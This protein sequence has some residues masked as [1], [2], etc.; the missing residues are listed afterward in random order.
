KM[1]FRPC[2]GENGMKPYHSP[3]LVTE[4]KYRTEVKYVLGGTTSSTRQVT[5]YV[6]HSLDQVACCEATHP[7]AAWFEAARASIRPTVE[8]DGTTSLDNPFIKIV[9]HTASGAQAEDFLSLRR[10][11]RLSADKKLLLIRRTLASR[12]TL[13]AAKSNSCVGLSIGVP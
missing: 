7:D 9:V 6:H 4:G 3:E 10:T 5:Y 13:A 12:R 1:P 8:F 11:F 2:D